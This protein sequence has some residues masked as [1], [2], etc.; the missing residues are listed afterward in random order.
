MFVFLAVF[1][2]AGFCFAQD[3]YGLGVGEQLAL[4]D[5]DPRILIIRIIQIVLGFLGLLAVG[6]IIYAGFLWMTSAGDESKVERAKKIIINAVIGIVIILSSLAIA[7]YV[8]NKLSEAVDGSEMSAPRT[9]GGGR[10]FGLEGAGI[11][12][13]CSIESVYPEPSQKNVPR[14]TSIL[15][16]FKEEINPATICTNAISG[17]C[18]GSELISDSVRIYKT[19]SGSDNF[20]SSV[21]VYNAS[22]RKNFIFSPAE[23]LGS[24]LEDILY[25]IYLSDNIKTVSGSTVFE[26]C[27]SDFMEWSFEVSNK[28]DLTPPQ[29]KDGGVWPVADNLADVPVSSPAVWASGRVVVVSQPAVYKVASVSGLSGPPA[30]VLVDENSGQDGNLSLTVLADGIKGVLRNETKGLNIATANFNARNEITFPGVLVL[31][32][33]QA[34]EAGNFWTMSAQAVV[35]ADTLTIGREVYV[36]VSGTA[37]S[38]NQ[39]PLGADRASTAGNIAAIIT[40]HPDINASSIDQVVNI[41]SAIGGSKGNN[42]IISSSDASKLL[43]TQLSG[44]VD[45]GS[46]VT[47]KDQK[48]KSMNSLIKINFNEPVLPSAVVGSA[49]NVSDSLQ[50]VNNAALNVL[51]GAAC[52]T[53]SDCRSFY[54][55]GGLCSGNYLSGS[56]SIANQYKTVE[57][58]SDKQ[59]GVNG[60]GE[61]IYCL[62]ASGNIRVEVRAA[63]LMACASGND[64][65]G[66]S[67]YSQCSGGFCRNSEGDNYPQANPSLLN[68]ITDVAFNSLDGNRDGAASGPASFY[69]ENSPSVAEGDNF[70]WSF[71]ISDKM[72]ISSP[73]IISLYPALNASG[74]SLN[75]DVEITFNKPMSAA[76]L[77]TGF[78]EIK[79]GDDKFIH[80][81]INIWSLSDTPIGYWIESADIDSDS[82]GETDGGRAIIKHGVFAEV[83]DYRAQ[84]GSGVRD[85]YQNCYKPSSGPGCAATENYPSCCNGSPASV[86][87]SDG[88]CL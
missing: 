63:S 65:A 2:V 58:I 13:A 35:Q 24:A 74:I 50:I 28:L 70:A 88:S 12:G 10:I 37:E 41:T 86:L 44:G 60:C 15:V 85:V 67:P 61:P 25:S 11:I 4:G 57:F 82:D 45:A 23:Y 49:D 59:C 29:V 52:S 33:D 56:F 17:L 5:T 78:T 51:N 43:I 62:P 75:D 40:K 81:N 66:K 54:C 48:D 27:G 30:S 80:K 72:E 19:A 79:S 47:I 34:V 73:A 71:F 68:G 6:L 42:I 32:A 26:N 84:V 18:N 83:L 21:R 38:G 8:I 31:R 46:G 7:T 16:T 77:K 3:S 64:C 14:N 53:D 55:S 9:D 87:S 1:S 69:Y 20:L 76:S 36:F 22:D 39:I